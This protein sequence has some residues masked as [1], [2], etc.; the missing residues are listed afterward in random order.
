MSWLRDVGY[1]VP[2]PGAARAVGR[3]LLSVFVLLMVVEPAAAKKRPRVAC[4]DGRFLVPHAVL[5]PGDFL[6]VP[7]GF[8]PQVA[9]VLDEGPTVAI[10]TGCTTPVRAKVRVRRNDITTI[11]AR[12]RSCEGL[13]GKVK[14]NAKIRGPEC[15]TIQGTLV[16]KKERPRKRRFTAPRSQCGD[17]VLDGGAGEGCEPAGVGTCGPNCQP[18]ARV[19]G[20]FLALSYNVA[21]LPAMFSGSEPETNTPLIAPLLNAYDLVLLQESWQTPDPNPLAP[22]RVYHEIL[23]AGSAHPYKSEPAVPPLGTDPERPAALLGDGLNR[24]SR[25]PF[26][27]VTRQRWAGC[28]VTSAD[29][30]ALKGFSMARTTL[31]DGVTVDVY[32]LHMEA[33]GAPEDDQRRAEGA[34]QLAAFIAEQSAGHAVIV[35]G[36]FNLHSDEEPDATTFQGLLGAAGLT[37][38]CADLDCPEPGRIDKFL[39]RSNEQ[40]TITPVSWKFE[41]ETFRRDDGEPLSDH[42]A[43]AVRFEW[44]ASVTA[45]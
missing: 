43:L 40:L 44:T 45:E 31:A 24:F 23:A 4:S 1:R 18:L 28:W 13:R 3:I 32:N 5:F 33:G 39:F 22:V 34:A 37:D 25:F 42:D 11:R 26:G 38:V 6:L 14:L 17:R 12:W 41:T 8:V 27:E 36:D 30:L 16:A 20:D 15:A 2:W 7:D 19:G 10:S 35:G 21:G 29:C 9:L